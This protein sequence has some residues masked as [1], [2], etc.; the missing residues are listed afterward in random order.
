MDEIKDK[1]IGGETS[2]KM[3][4]DELC[5]MVGA[6]LV[7]KLVQLQ[8]DQIQIS[9]VQEEKEERREAAR[10]KLATL[11]ERNANLRLKRTT[12]RNKYVALLDK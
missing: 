8:S 2:T 9:N 6:I 5:S 4:F 7:R 11:R 1:F 3:A 10:A 12:L